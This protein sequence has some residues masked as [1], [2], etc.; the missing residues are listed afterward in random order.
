MLEYQWVPP[1]AYATVICTCD[2]SRRCES[3][4]REEANCEGQSDRNCRMDSHNGLRAFRIESGAKSGIPA[5]FAET[6]NSLR[7]SERR[8]ANS[9]LRACDECFLYTLCPSTLA[10]FNLSNSLTKVSSKEQ[11]RPASLSGF[12]SVPFLSL[13]PCK[14]SHNRSSSSKAA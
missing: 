5:R 3:I 1:S 8:G 14:V 13:Y 11:A 6:E 4:E 12:G 9:W 10:I 7:G 2:L